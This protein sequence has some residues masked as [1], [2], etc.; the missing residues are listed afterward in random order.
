MITH[1]SRFENAR[2]VPPGFDPKEP[3][4]ETGYRGIDQGESCEGSPRGVNIDSS[5][6]VALR[7][8]EPSE[9]GIG[10]QAPD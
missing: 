8:L 1:D 6:H 5:R 7:G 4:Q 10:G 3:V 2:T 9:T